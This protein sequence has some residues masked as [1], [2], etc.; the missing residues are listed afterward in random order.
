MSVAVVVLELER[1]EPAALWFATAAVVLF[2]CLD[3]Y[4][5]RLEMAFRHRYDS[6]AALPMAEA[7]DLSIKPGQ[8]TVLRAL[9]SPAI[10]GFYP[11]QL[12]ALALFCYKI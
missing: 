4:Y 2:G 1:W 9:R 7:G 11:L 8:A 10:W 3:T 5:L 12:V 6:V